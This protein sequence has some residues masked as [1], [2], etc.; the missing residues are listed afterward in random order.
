[1]SIFLD[2]EL[3]EDGEHQALLAHGAA[4]F[5]PLLFRECDQFGRR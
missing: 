4:I 5:D 3:L 2:R 1:M